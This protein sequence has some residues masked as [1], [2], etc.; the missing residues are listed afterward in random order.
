MGQAVAEARAHVQGSWAIAVDNASGQDIP[1]G[2]S[3]GKGHVLMLRG[4]EAIQIPLFRWPTGVLPALPAASSF[5]GAGPG[6]VVRR[7]PKLFVIE[8]QTDDE[9][10]TDLFLGLIERLP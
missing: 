6:W 10:V 5:V 3:V 8:A 4:D 1:L 2:E 7:D 9:N